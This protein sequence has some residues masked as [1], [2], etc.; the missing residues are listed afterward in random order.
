VPYGGEA[1][2]AKVIADGKGAARLT[3]CHANGV[4]GFLACERKA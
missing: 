1:R 4:G 2:L 3:S